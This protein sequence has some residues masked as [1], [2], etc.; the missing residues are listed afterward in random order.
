MSSHIL[1]LVQHHNGNT[2]NTDRHIESRDGGDDRPRFFLLWSSIYKECAVTS[3]TGGIRSW[4]FSGYICLLISLAKN[5]LLPHPASVLG[6]T[7]L[8][9]V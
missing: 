8:M 3:D 7:I 1:R 9:F 5:S 2:G 4:F 6:A